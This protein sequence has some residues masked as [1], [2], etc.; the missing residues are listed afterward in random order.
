MPSWDGL[1]WLNDRDMPGVP[2]Y[3]DSKITINWARQ[4]QTRSNLP[5]NP[6]TLDAIID[7]EEALA[8]L[9]R[10]KPRNPII[11]WDKRVRGENPADFGR[12]IE[13]PYAAPW[14]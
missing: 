11:W 4:R 1:K 9:K 12:K 2:V 7:L 5:R 14:E 6:E 8:W 13:E 3:S 10:N